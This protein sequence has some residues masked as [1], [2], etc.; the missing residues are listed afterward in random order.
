VGSKVGAEHEYEMHGWTGGQ[1]MGVLTQL[2]PHRFDET[3]CLVAT[4]FPAIW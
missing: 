4:L 3:G 2:G 1:A